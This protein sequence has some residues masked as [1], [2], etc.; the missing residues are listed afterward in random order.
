MQIL[1]LSMPFIV[2][3]IIFVGGWVMGA[4]TGWYGLMRLYPDRDEKPVRVFNG[5]TG[6]MKGLAFN[7]ILTL[8]VCAS[9][10]RVAVP[11]LFGPFSKPFFIPWDEIRAYRITEYFMPA[12]RLE[13]G[14]PAKGVLGMRATT[15]NRLARA[16]GKNWPEAGPFPFET[17]GHILASVILMWALMS[18]VGAGF[19][20]V[21]PM[22]FAPAAPYLP[23]PVAVSFPAV[24]MGLVACVQFTVLANASDAERKTSA[25]GG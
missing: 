7:G 24:V 5:Q 8:S 23:I 12:V 4:Q 3:G 21:L 22:V 1:L 15:A 17:T 18:A 6:W 9:G 11:R 20:I 10:L 16:A 2:I 19:L 13:F 25:A 14:Q